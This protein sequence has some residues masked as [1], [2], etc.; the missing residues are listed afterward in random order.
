MNLLQL[1]ERQTQKS[2]NLQH[3]LFQSTK[4]IRNVLP[5]YDICRSSCRRCSVKKLLLKISQISQENIEEHLWKTASSDVLSRYSN[6]FI[7]HNITYFILQFSEIQQFFEVFKLLNY[8]RFFSLLQSGQYN[9][10]SE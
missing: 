9:R 8:F 3:E 10:N 6:E 4:K 1:L 5:R 7:S 2:E